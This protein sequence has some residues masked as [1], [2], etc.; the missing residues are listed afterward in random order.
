MDVP[1]DNRSNSSVSPNSRTKFIEDEQDSES[2][3]AADDTKEGQN[4]DDSSST[5]ADDVESNI[6][7][8]Q[9]LKDIDNLLVKRVLQLVVE[10]ETQAR[11]L[12]MHALPKG[13]QAEVLLRA[14]MV[15]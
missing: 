8:E 9:A 3:S 10:L 13:S 15:R 2:P 1:T 5:K 11:M 4:E 7:G 14:D 12:L 6:A